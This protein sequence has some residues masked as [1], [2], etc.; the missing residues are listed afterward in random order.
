MNNPSFMHTEEEPEPLLRLLLFQAFEA[1]LPGRGKPVFPSRKA[2]WLLALLALR[3]GRETEREWLAGVLW[4]DSETQKALF[5][6]R[7]TL[8]GLRRALG[9][10]AGCLCSVGK[11]GLRLENTGVE[12][13]V[14]RFDAAIVAG[15]PA[16]LEQAIHLYRGP[17]LVD[18]LEEWVVPERE[19]RAQA[20]LDALEQ[21]AQFALSGGER[22]V[23]THW[24]RRLCAA[25][26]YR[27]SAACALMQVLA[28]S[29]DRAALRQVYDHLRR[30]LHDDLNA[31]PAPET[32]A[33]FH[34]LNQREAQAVA[35][36]ASPR[37][38]A[39]SLR[40]LPVP[41]TDLIGREQEIEDGVGWLERCRLVTLLGP[42][43][44][45][46]TRLAIAVAESALPQFADGVWFVDFAPLQD[47]SRVPETVAR[48]LGVPEEGRAP[49]EAL[50]ETLVERALLLVLDNCEHV[51]D[52]CASLAYGLLS[53]CPHV[54]VLATSRHTLGVTGEQV[55]PVPSLELPPKEVTGSSSSP[56][57]ME[58]DPA[59]LMDYAGV[60]LFVQRALQAKPSFRLERRNAAIVAAICRH[61]D[62]IPLAIEMAAARL[63]SL[64]LSEI[65]TRLSDRFRLLTTGNRATL[66]RHQTLYATIQWSDSLLSEP[67]RRF[68]R[69]LSVF[70]GG[71][72]EE[73]AVQI[74]GMGEETWGLLSALVDKSLITQAETEG[75]S[76]YGMLESVRHY[77]WEQL[78][79]G[80]ELERLQRERRD[81]CLSLA[82]RPEA[83][84]YD[85]ARSEWV[86]RIASEYDNLQAA[87]DFCEQDA[88][89]LQIGLRIAAGLHRFWTARGHLSEGHRRC[90]SL[91]GRPGADA[92][93]EAR[94]NILTTY[95][96]MMNYLSDYA[97]IP[98]LVQEALAI[99]RTT[100]NRTGE[101][102]ALLFLSFCASTLPERY[103][104][105][106]ESLTLFREIEDRMGIA[107]A[108]SEL[109]GAANVGKE[110]ARSQRYMA[111]ALSLYRQL[112]KP[113]RIART[114][115]NM[116]YHAFLRGDYATA[117]ELE[118][119]ALQGHREMGDRLGELIDLQ[120]LAWSCY[121]LGEFT[122]ALAYCEASLSIQREVWRKQEFATS[123]TLL[124]DI[125]YHHQEF[126]RMVSLSAAADNFARRYGL[127]ITSG[128]R[129]PLEPMLAMAQESLGTALFSRSWEKGASMTLEE[130]LAFALPHAG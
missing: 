129:E 68:L 121:Y 29:G 22:T 12:T 100:E 83:E 35:S 123:L 106:E 16:A 94:A 40:H 26:P 39:P 122:D 61:L 69:R 112:K 18:C 101:A 13:D 42:G 4:P 91:L 57:L 127:D 103:R 51:Q 109:G 14:A 11:N 31:V 92:P 45:G 58:K 59:S 30:R 44:V 70:R 10:S 49:E 47:A 53:A 98:T 88:G 104:L 87:L 62:G 67:E 2:Q 82:E 9:D 120:S 36:P 130:A 33:L 55:Y 84:R 76:R 116:S 1:R 113:R 28:D 21:R 74:G 56:T 25:D 107:D 7:Q 99:Y 43:G 19:R 86:S 8:G 64:S 72:T 63:R 38:A 114:L 65:E 126:R 119:E 78:E 32:E 95:A 111:E 50:R 27:E 97:D 75:V 77:Y 71:W 52:A 23:A 128:R 96:S 15:T 93:T 54:K 90:A 46:K 6:L 17:L 102:R 24:L 118:L 73:G 115:H 105:N 34:G 41:L 79:A 108:I 85:E 37:P 5:N 124:A 110:Y 48:T 60:R 3:Q 89:S 66:P 80:G 81:Y 125:A 20:Y 117:K